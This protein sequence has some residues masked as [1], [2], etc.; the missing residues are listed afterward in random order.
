[1]FL[2]DGAGTPLQN[3]PSQSPPYPHPPISQMGPPA[4]ICTVFCSNNLTAREIRFK[5]YAARKA[6]GLAF[7]ALDRTHADQSNDACNAKFNFVSAKR[8][9]SYACLGEPYVAL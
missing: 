1:M 8:G 6:D 7:P 5:T 2:V 4:S 9:H 3:S